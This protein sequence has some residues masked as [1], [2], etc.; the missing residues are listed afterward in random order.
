MRFS[1]FLM[2]LLWI[3]SGTMWKLSSEHIT[4]IEMTLRLHS[5]YTL[6]LCGMMS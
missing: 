6:L 4:E 3:L 5:K 2:V 1:Y